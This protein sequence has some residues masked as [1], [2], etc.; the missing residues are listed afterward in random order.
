M[1][2]QESNQISS[3]QNLAP[4]VDDVYVMP[5]KFQ[6][7]AV[8]STSALLISIIVLLIVILGIGGY[9]G[10]IYYNKKKIP[11]PVVNDNNAASEFGNE[12]EVP[13]ST[14]EIATSTEE[15]ITTSTATSTENSMPTSTESNGQIALTAVSVSPD[16]DQDGLTDL[17]ENLIGSSIVNA[18]SD[19]DGFKDGDELLNGYSPLIPDTS[20]KAKIENAPFI[21]LAKTDFIG[22]NFSLPI[23]K[24]W[25]FSTIKAT[26]Q[27]IITTETGEIIK[28]SVKDNP[29]ALSVLDWYTRIN[30]Q[31]TP[32]QL[33]QVEYGSLSGII[34]P[35][36]L[37]AYLTNPLKTK[38][39]S[40]EYIMDSGLQMRYPT[41]F[42]MMI[43]KY[44]LI[45]DIEAKST[46]TASTSETL[47]P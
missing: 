1:T 47:A 13:T 11:A 14:E 28:I 17:E 30:P 42:K 16:T 10:Y 38:I 35:D 39:Y 6:P 19:K 12:N 15:Q 36:N 40:F 27:A 9:F 43:K 24:Q 41:L 4:G 44:S 46:T 20:V 26:K 45:S 25:S 31:I 21:K 32:M 5:E 2:N 3:P 8:K 23:L 7:R 22:D 18:D 33:L 34:S 29:G 37:S